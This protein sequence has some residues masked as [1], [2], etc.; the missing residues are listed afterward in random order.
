VLAWLDQYRNVAGQCIVWEVAVSRG[1]QV[2][3]H[4]CSPFMHLGILAFRS[5][6]R[7]YLFF[8]EREAGRWTSFAERGWQETCCSFRYETAPTLP[9]FP[10]RGPGHDFDELVL[11]QHRYRTRVVLFC[12]RWSFSAFCEIF[13]SNKT[14]RGL[15]LTEAVLLPSAVYRNVFVV[16]RRLNRCL[17]CHFRATLGRTS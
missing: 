13:V 1:Q 7:E 2:E 12:L 5:F 17:K 9:P 8:R 16:C 10:E 14:A 4:L 6:Q 15:G 3:K 11:G